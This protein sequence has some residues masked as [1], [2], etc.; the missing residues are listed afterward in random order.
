MT[1]EQIQSMLNEGY[2]L[3]QI[4]AIHMIGKQTL[5]DILDSGACA[6][7]IAKGMSKSIPVETVSEFNAKAELISTGTKG[8]SKPVV[9][10]GIQDKQYFEE[11][12]GL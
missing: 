6:P 1:R 12:P 4:A 11:E 8:E 7:I 3:N 10:Y 9:N 5:Q 2:N